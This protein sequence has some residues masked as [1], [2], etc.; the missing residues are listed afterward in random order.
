MRFTRGWYGMVRPNIQCVVEHCI[1]VEVLADLWSSRKRCKGIPREG[2]QCKHGRWPP[3]PYR[4]GRGA[5]NC[6][7]PFG[8]DRCR[9]IS[10]HF[11]KWILDRIRILRNW[12]R[13]INLN[14]WINFVWFLFSK[15]VN[16]LIFL[17]QAGMLPS[18]FPRR[19]TR[20]SAENGSS[21]YPGW[22]WYKATLWK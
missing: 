20:L 9:H 15:P 14:F 17:P 18:H 1:G 2:P 6:L 19:H 13:R 16:P 4:D 21:T 22:Q 3:K 5:R 10:L 7:R 11:S 8:K 12:C